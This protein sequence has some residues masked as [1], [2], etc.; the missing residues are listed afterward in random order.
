MNMAITDMLTPEAE[1]QRVQLEKQLKH[2]EI[3]KDGEGNIKYKNLGEHVL[4][5]LRNLG[6][7]L[8]VS[9]FYWFQT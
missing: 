5:I 1:E 3:E 6:L 2:A 9:L 7:K 4:P 8:E